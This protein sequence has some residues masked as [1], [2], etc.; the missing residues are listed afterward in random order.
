MEGGCCC[1][2]HPAM[3][4][5][6]RTGASAACAARENGFGVIVPG[7]R[8]VRESPGDA[9]PENVLLYRRPVNTYRAVQRARHLQGLP[10]AISMHTTRHSTARPLEGAEVDRR[11]RPFRDTTSWTRKNTDT[12]TCCQNLVTPETAEQT[13]ARDSLDASSRSARQTA[14]ER[15]TPRDRA[16]TVRSRVLGAGDRDIALGVAEH[17]E[18][19]HGHGEGEPP[20][21]RT[22]SR[23]TQMG[24]PRHCP[25]QERCIG[26]RRQ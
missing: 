16:R 11:R 15:G 18:F 25:Q 2:R 19:A 10:I 3:H 17:H 14:R 9:S 13:R 22:R 5:R 24:R 23:G 12:F 6:R 26:C 20:F 4:S 7:V 1:A 8:V 21:T